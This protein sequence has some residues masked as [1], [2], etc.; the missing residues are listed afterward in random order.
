MLVKFTLALSRLYQIMNPKVASIVFTV[1]YLTNFNL[2]NSIK[3]VTRGNHHRH[4]NP[5]CHLLCVLFS[6]CIISHTNIYNRDILFLL[7]IL[8]EKCRM[9]E[10]LLKQL[11]SYPII[12]M[13]SLY[14][15]THPVLYIKWKELHYIWLYY[16]TKVSFN[17]PM[18]NK[19]KP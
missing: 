19:M 18:I 8:R 5:C 16:Q 2:A 15:A 4:N 1:A 7:P 17:Y 12:Y 13:M 9:S 14:Y 10:T 3:L 11:L 6:F